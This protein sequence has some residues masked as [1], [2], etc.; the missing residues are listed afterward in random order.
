MTEPE[1]VPKPLLYIRNATSLY[2]PDLVRRCGGEVFDVYVFDANLHVHCCSITPSYEMFFFDVVPLVWPENEA[3][4]DTLYDDLAGINIG[5]FEE[6][7]YFDAT[8]WLRK[9]A[10]TG[11]LSHRWDYRTAPFLVDVYPTPQV[12][13]W[14]ELLEEH[15]NR[16]DAHREFMDTV[17]EDLHGNARY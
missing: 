1:I 10:E 8:G 5:N 14:E 12:E 11:D 15:E 13:T 2:H 9:E 7:S 3:E 16:R 17:L 6:V 4:R